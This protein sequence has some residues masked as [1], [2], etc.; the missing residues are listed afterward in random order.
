MFDEF[1]TIGKLKACIKENVICLIPK[2]EDSIHVKDFRPISLT[3]IQKV[4]SKVMAER[5]RNVMPCII[6]STSAC[7]GGRQIL[8]LILIV[9]E[10]V[11]DCRAK[12]R[13]GWI[14]RKLST[15]SIGVFLIEFV[16]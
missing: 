15:R 11:E 2:K 9:N 7:I 16:H 14:L 10:A 4:L 3:S 8:N 5:I 6:S 12:K 1:H 13:K